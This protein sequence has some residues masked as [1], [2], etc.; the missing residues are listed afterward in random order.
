MPSAVFVAGVFPESMLCIQNTLKASS[1]MESNLRKE[2]L[3]KIRIKYLI[4]DAHKAVLIA[5]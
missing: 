5:N 1:W 2:T 3:T 4:T